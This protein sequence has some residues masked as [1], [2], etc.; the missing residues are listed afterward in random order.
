MKL[1]LKAPVIVLLI[2][3]FTISAYAQEELWKQLNSKVVMLYQQGRYAEAAEVAEEAL[4][5]A[6]K[7]FES[8]H[9]DVA[10]SLNNLALLYQAQGKFAEAEPLYKR[11]LKIVEKALGPEHPYV[12]ASL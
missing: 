4:T 9:P 1:V 5:V 11:S 2:I 10:T 12:A 3:S 8:N 6:E 7:T